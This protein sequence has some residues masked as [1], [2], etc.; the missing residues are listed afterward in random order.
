[1][2]VALSSNGILKVARENGKMQY[3]NRTAGG[4]SG[5]PCFDEQWRVV[6][7]HRAERSK[8]FGAVREGIL[9]ESILPRLNASII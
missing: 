6:G 1:M 8:A 5:A 3:V 2:K 4:G 9:L 7:V